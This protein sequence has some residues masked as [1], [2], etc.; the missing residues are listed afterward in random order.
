MPPIFVDDGSLTAMSV[1]YVNELKYVIDSFYQKVFIER[2]KSY[3]D[4]M[5]DGMEIL[6]K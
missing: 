4:A 1:N 2:D 5:I 3:E 6:L